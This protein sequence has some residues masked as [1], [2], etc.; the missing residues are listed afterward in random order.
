MEYSLS[1][2]SGYD[3]NVMRF[4]QNEF[5]NATQNLDLLGGANTFDSFVTKVGLSGKKPIWISGKK[6]IQLN[7]FINYSDY[8]HSPEKKYWSGG[9]DASFKWGSYRS[10]KYS[11]RHLDQFY[12]RH[13]I[14]RDISTTKLDACAFTDRNHSLTLT[15]RITRR[16]WVNITPGV[17][18]RYYN[19]P[20]TE[21]DLD[22]YY[23]KG[24]LNYKIKKVGTIAMQIDMGQAMSESHYLPNRPSSFNRSY[25]TMEWYVPIKFTKNVPFLDEIGISAREETRIYVA[26]DL[27]DPLHAGRSHKDT[28]YDLWVKKRIFET[29][30]V[31]F[32]TRYRE[33]QTDSAY[34]WVADLKSFNQMQCWLKVEWDFIYDRY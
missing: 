1:F 30:N 24:K 6:S 29:M 22:I 33:R 27:N 8:I 14:N 16:I 12:L 26:E 15:D 28:K 32:T 20:F 19:N 34:K 5:D 4:S 21:F 7:G 9:L 13:Y 25:E 23:V 10:L 11:I 2:T 31:S 3:N 18:Q 17:L